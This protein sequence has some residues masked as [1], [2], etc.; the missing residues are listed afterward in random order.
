MYVLQLLLSLSVCVRACVSS[1]VRVCVCAC[2]RA[3]VCT[4]VRVCVCACVQTAGVSFQYMTM[5]TY[6]RLGHGQRESADLPPAHVRHLGHLARLVDRVLPLVHHCW[7]LS[8]EKCVGGI[9]EMCLYTRSVLKYFKKNANVSVFY[10][11]RK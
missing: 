11:S 6:G 10:F 2:V 7:V 5:L 3:C 4:C 9:R 1:F 8:N